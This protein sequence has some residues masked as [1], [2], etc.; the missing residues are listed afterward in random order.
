MIGFINSLVTHTLNYTLIHRQYS[1]ITDLQTLQF[2]VPHAL[3]F[4]VS[5]SRLL[6]TEVT[7][8]ITPKIFQLHFQYRCTVAYKVFNSHNTYSQSN[9]LYSSVL[10]VSIRLEDSENWTVQSQS[11]SQIA[12]D[13][14]L[15]SK[16]LCR[17]PSGAHDYIFIAVWQLRSCSLWGT[18]SEKKTGLSFVHA[19]GP[20]QRSLSRVRV[21][22]YPRP[23]LLSQIW[24]FPFRRLYDSQGH[25]GGIRPR[26]HTGLSLSVTCPAYNTSARTAQ[27]TPFPVVLL[28]C[29][30]AVAWTA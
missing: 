13:G 21:P 10:L 18:L 26:L 16:S 11:Q 23:Y 14:Q 25:G 20:C 9:L 12:T 17:A 30:V 8:I 27:K 3:G 15:V 5:T 22:W 7:T 24:D 6:A 4:S 1:A 19:A 2:T 29:H 28:F